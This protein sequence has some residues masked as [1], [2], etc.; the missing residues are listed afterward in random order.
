MDKKVAFIFPGQ[1]TQYVGMGQD[2]SETFSIARETLEE[3][4]DLIGYNLMNLLFKGPEERLKRTDYSQ[5]AIYLVGLAIWRVVKQEFPDIQPSV[6]A[7][8][9]LGEYTALSASGR[10]SFQEGVDLVCARGRYMHEAGTKSCG[11]MVVVLGMEE[12]RVRATLKS[13][14]GVW[15]ANLNCPRQVVISGKVASVTKASLLLKQMGAKRIVP[16]NVSGAFHT[17][18]MVEAKKRL[19]EKIETIEIKESSIDLVMNVMGD[20]VS[21]DGI[22][23]NMVQQVVAPVYWEKG[24]RNME[25][26][27]VNLFIEIGPGQT[28]SG[29][30]RK[31]GVCGK[32]FSIGEVRDLDRLRR[33]VIDG[34]T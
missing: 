24:I 22:R 20:F 14:Q 7:G 5:I 26:S 31:I 21:Q 10:L 17:E 15:L 32:T 13:I 29:M 4:S 28:L 33:G 30:N 6:V 27:G 25:K 9:S 18:L 19:E 3:G 34:F 12:D 16:L 8:L 2:F 1:G 23:E 11:T